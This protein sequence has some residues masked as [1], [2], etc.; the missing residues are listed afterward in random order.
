[1]RQEYIQILTKQSTEIEVLRSERARLTEYAERQTEYAEQQTEKAIIASHALRERES[2]LAW[3]T[4]AGGQLRT[5]RVWSRK[6]K[7]RFCAK[8]VRAQVPW[9][10]AY[11]H[12]Q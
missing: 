9:Y 11:V 1:M 7:T 6:M 5:V 8:L 10:S 12:R 3:A 2:E 4:A